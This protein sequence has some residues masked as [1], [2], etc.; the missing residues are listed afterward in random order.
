MVWGQLALNC[1]RMSSVKLTTNQDASRE[2]QLADS[3]L[4]YALRFNIRD[5]ETLFQLAL[6][7]KEY[8]R[9]DFADE[10]LRRSLKCSDNGKDVSVT[11]VHLAEVMMAQANYSEAL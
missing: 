8:Q 10:L 5:A 11:R 1:F 3:C 4:G 2:I 6:Y 7:Y 9:Y